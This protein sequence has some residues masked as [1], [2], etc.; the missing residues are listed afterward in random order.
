MEIWT[1]RERNCKGIFMKKELEDLGKEKLQKIIL[2]MAEFLTREQRQKLETLIEN[3]VPV[4]AVAETNQK[5]ARMSREYVD[6][7]MEQIRTWMRQIDEAELYLD[8]EEYED[9]S[10]SYWD[11]EWVVEY[12]DNQGV[13]DK[14]MTAIRFAKDCVDDQQY[15]EANEIYEWIW[16][17]EVGAQSDYDDCDSAGL[18]ELV[19]NKIVSTDMNQLALLTLYADYQV[20]EPAARAEDMYLYFSNETFQKLHVEDM[21]HA[22]REELTDTQ[23]FWEDWIR[24]LQSKSGDVETRLLQ[25]AVLHCDGLEGLVKMA[26]ENCKMHP[27]LYITVMDEYNK[28]HDYEQIE[29]IGERAVEKISRE[30]IIRRAAAL[31]A[32]QAA[33]FLGHTEKVMQFCWEAFCS[34]STV[35]NF[36]RL[37]G[38]EEMAVQYG[39]RGKEVLGS[40]IQNRQVGE[41]IRNQ[42]LR[43]N[44]IGDHGYHELCFYTGDFEAVKK[45][46]KNPQ[47]SLGWSSSFIRRGI[48]L[49]LLY[50]YENPK[51]SKAAAAVASTVGF[52]GNADS[53]EALRFENDII[54]ESKRN[55]VSVFWSY[56]QRWKR[57]FPMEEAER[58]RYLAW[59]EKTARSRADAIVGGQ[60]RDHYGSSAVLLA[61]VAEI[62]EEMGIQGAK[63]EIFA[64]YKAK[65]PRHSSFQAEMKTYFNIK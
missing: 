65:F 46:S 58:K 41:M 64:E 44:M 55:K 14:L 10:V 12:S 30:L 26:D 57:Y 59:A 24:L 51:P 49:F 3:S 21:F 54:E 27:S 5:S 56:F 20:Q 13:G 33:D 8:A 19:E 1:Y 25:E 38:T 39:M 50:L 48:R 52:F 47:G 29:K 43:P 62:K 45:A 4:R 16:D 60:H 37:F 63:R 53:C 31:K 7:K 18:Q 15:R 40:G 11:R 9:Y 42:E 34:D 6:E 23:Q 2:D 61:L 22:G 32:A 28:S 35:R 36:L 17:M